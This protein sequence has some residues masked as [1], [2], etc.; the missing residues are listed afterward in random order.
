MDGPA[1][2]VLRPLQLHLAPHFRAPWESVS[3][4]AFW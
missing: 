2:L 1:A 4:A 3:I